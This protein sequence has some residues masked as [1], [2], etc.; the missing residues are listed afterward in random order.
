MFFISTTIY[1]LSPL[2]IVTSLLV[3]T[4]RSIQLNLI[5]SL[6]IFNR[7][8]LLLFH[9]HTAFSFFFLVVCPIFSVPK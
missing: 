2:P 5:L 7:Y 1:S 4:H 8:S 9:L 3:Y 6:A